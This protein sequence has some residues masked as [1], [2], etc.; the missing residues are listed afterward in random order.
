M[1]YLRHAACMTPSWPSDLSAMTSLIVNGDDCYWVM[2]IVICRSMPCSLWLINIFIKWSLLVI[3]NGLH[4][5]LVAGSWFF[6][7]HMIAQSTQ[8]VLNMLHFVSLM[9]TVKWQIEIDISGME[10]DHLF[11]T[12]CDL[13]LPGIICSKF[14]MISV[15]ILKLPAY[16]AT[17]T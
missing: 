5:L 6:S 10:K 8:E 11:K 17:Y 1:Q 13:I 12:I 15:M 9:S 2:H 4:F 7:V 16:S 3:E 14:S